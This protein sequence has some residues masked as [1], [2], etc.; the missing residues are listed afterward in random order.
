VLYV[1][2]IVCMMVLALRIACDQ[3]VA[4]QNIGNVFD[5]LR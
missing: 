1:V 4:L 3:M 2:G 5:L